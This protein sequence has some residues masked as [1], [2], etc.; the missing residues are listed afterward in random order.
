LPAQDVAAELKADLAAGLSDEA[1]NQRLQQQ[2]FNE[3]ASIPPV[4]AWRRFLAQFLELVVGILVVAAIISAAMGDW[5]DAVAIAAIVLL[6]GVLGFVQEERAEQ[7]LAALRNMAKPKAKVRRGGHLKEVPFIEITPGDVIEVEAGDQ[8]PADARLVR[9]FR[10]ETQEAALTGEST[11][12]E[13]EAEAV[14]AADTP[15]AERRNLVFMG[16]SVA[17]GS[18]TAIVFATGMQTE[19]GHIAGLLQNQEQEITPLQRRLGELGRILIVLCLA[20]VAIIFALQWTR[21]EPLLRVLMLAVGLAV[22]AVPEGL[23]AV[24]T[25][26]LALGVQ[27]MAKR[28]AL[29]RK[30]PGVETLGCVTVICSDKTGTLTRNQMTVRE[31]VVDGARLQVTGGGYE[32]QGKFLDEQK[33][34]IDP[35]S[36]QRLRAMLEAATWCN[37]AKLTEPKPG[38]Q[39][40]VVGDPTEGALLVAAQK[41]GVHADRL[42]GELVFEVPFDSQRKAMSVVVAADGRERV[43]TKGAPEEVL[44]NCRLDEAKKQAIRAQVSD[45]A[46]Q[47]MRV[48]ALAHRPLK[49]GEDGR[50]DGIEKDLEF[51]GLMGMIDPPREEVKDSVAT[52]RTAG[53]RPV[54]ITGDH[55]DT[56]IAIGKELHIAHDGDRALTGQDLERM[57]DDDLA[58]KVEQVAIYARVTAAHK[59]RIVKAWQKRGQVVAMTGDGV[60]DAPALKAADIGVAMGVTGTDVTKEASDMVLTDDNFTSI[61][62]AVEEGR[63]IYDNIQ[64]FILYLLASNVSEVLVMFFAA[65]VGWPPPLMPIQLLWINLVTDG[66]P[67][68]ALTMEPPEPDLMQRSPRPA[69]EPVI[70]WQRGLQIGTFGILMALVAVGGFWWFYHGDEERVPLARTATF[71]ILAFTQLF[72]SLSCR[73]QRYTTP[74]LGL[75]SNRYL[76]GAIII[77]GLVQLTVVELPWTKAMFESDVEFTF[78]EWLMIFG[79]ALTPVTVIEIGKL[80]RKVLRARKAV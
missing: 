42:S 28:N 68:L 14:L 46:A 60:N 65:L 20:I 54:M 77:S 38:G 78:A 19:L 40:Q 22:A 15:L 27:R 29:V 21:G 36:N 74:E 33:R 57:S 16:T 51:L 39:W 63:G 45:M 53:I 34:E 6:N 61:I 58:G 41:A 25:V 11:G 30:L 66:L 26:A 18:A 3:L 47:A 10:L 59:L 35:A 50:S 31:V 80:V 17:T 71:C 69:R 62:S 4:P 76:I 44:S 24:V 70:T 43:F 12:T 49:D 7:S 1:A 37:H 23:P 75:F 67:A 5:A 52:C 48:L 64:K 73:S 79:L 8:I 72:Y 9:A 55:P 13:K 32:P 2:G 56:A